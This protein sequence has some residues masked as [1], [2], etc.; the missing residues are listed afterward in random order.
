MKQH[1]TDH[2]P[3]KLY[4]LEQL[5]ALDRI[6][7]EDFGVPGVELM[8]RAAESVFAVLM[9]QWP[10]VAH[11]GFVVGP[12]NKG[13]DAYALAMLA[14]QHE[15]E[16]SFYTV[17]DH[18]LDTLGASL[19]RTR[20]NA[21]AAGLKVEPFTGVIDN[22]ID[23]LIDGIVSVAGAVEGDYC[24][25][26]AA[27]NSHR[28]D[29][30]SLDFPSGL[31][32]DTGQCDPCTVSANVTVTFLG[33]KPGLLTASGPDYCGSI[34]C[35]TLGLPDALYEHLTSAIDRISYQ[36]L[37]K[38]NNMM[39]PRLGNTHKG[40][41]G[42]ALIVGGDRGFGGA[43]MLACESAARTGAG[44]VSCATQPDNVA[45]LNVR[46]PEVMAWG[47]ASGLELAPLIDRASVIAIGTGLGQSGWSEMLL[48]QVLECDLPMVLDAD[49]LNIIARYQQRPDF[50]Q[51]DVVMTPHPAEAARLL[52]CNLHDVQQDRFSAA[53][54][55]AQ[56]YDAVV[57]LK[58]QGSIVASPSGELA[59]CS[60]GNAGMSSGGMG[61]VLTGVVASILA[62]NLIRQT[63]VD[64]CS[65]H[66]RKLVTSPWDA[67]RLACCV[68][69]SAADEA[70]HLR[71]QRG[72][73][74]CDVIEYLTAR[75]NP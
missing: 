66:L 43:V 23:V 5:Y 8:T 24:Q 34:A 33:M 19:I 7:S 28:A 27:V 31:N 38:H 44:L 75:M 47:V 14:L 3:T 6:A 69:S 25:A 51:R 67:A 71:G 18:S 11:V 20:A 40:D 30:L 73:L 2:L 36:H 50:S 55:L 12:H 15:L 37:V 49:A 60:D 74:A 54:K 32:I 1:H 22:N 4:T 21:L 58:G 42:H 46:R 63:E 35:S 13:G 10:N 41:F 45:S 26:I 52:G 68:H 56:T 64:M 61:D 16:I 29:V 53:R 70:A 48:Q 39:V 62:Q 72:L 17:G 59:V 57:I 65:R 9:Q